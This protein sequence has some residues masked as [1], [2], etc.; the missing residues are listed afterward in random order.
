VSADREDVSV[1]D[2]YL[3]LL[4][5]RGMR[6]LFGNGG[7]D[8]GPIIDAY[9]R[10][11]A[12]GLPV[13]EPVTVPHEIVAV[14]MA[15]GYTM[16]T[17]DPQAVMVHTVAGT[18]NAIGG[19][20]N[21]NRS[22]IPMLFSAGR[23]PLTEGDLLGA[24]DLHIHW[25]QESFDQ[26][27]MAREWVKWDYELRAGA[28]L[29]GIVDRAI[30]ITQ[31][32][33]QAPVYLTLP[34]E[35]LAGDHP[36]ED[37]IERPR[38]NAGETVAAPNAV[39]QAAGVLAAADNPVL[40]TRS[41]GRDPLAVAPLTALAER[42]G[43][44]VID[45]YPTHLNMAQDHG[46]Y[47]ATD[48]GRYLDHADVVVVVE[49]DVPWTPKRAKPNPAATVIGIGA[50]P[51]HGSYPVRGFPVDLN[52]G[53]TVRLTLE[54]LNAALAHHPID[55]A[56]ALGRAERWQN[57]H[58]TLVEAADARAATGRDGDVLDKAWLSSCIE[59]LRSPD[60][61]IVN[62]LGFDTTQLRQTEPGTFFGVSGA[63]VLG[64][65][66][67]AA[68]GAKL[69]ASDRTVIACIGDGSYMF[70]APTAAHWVSR[71]MDLP[72]LYL[73]W[74]NATWGAVKRATRMVYPEGYAVKTGEFPFSDLG[75]SID[76][77]LICQ[78]AGGH[79]ERVED[80]AELPAALD[81]ALKAVKEEGRQALLNLIGPK[82]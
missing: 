6:Y 37:R 13:P 44:C 25:A 55:D 39:T 60:T 69:A 58:R 82:P 19:L 15:H 73:V 2:A 10:R 26:G 41:A 81:R 47:L 8:F 4:Q 28:D 63:G 45:P 16:V 9:A 3:D 27:S 51:L 68:L 64:W 49:S 65:G 53:G 76:Y 67:G 34:R 48:P 21:A 54:A 18:A 78:A 70:G 35:V 14:A 79:A 46:L 75:P 32:E 52:L 22:Q 17:G 38:M 57:D 24:R 50:D 29:E 11:L 33:P 74:N 80:P 43:M 71:R 30:A 23:T 61:I 31:T 62:E 12:D 20:I 72:V 7:T 66:L 5:T 40:I 59:E 77:E 56:V 42:L 1:A 36:P